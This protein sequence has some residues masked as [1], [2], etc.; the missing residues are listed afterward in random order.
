[1]AVK[2]YSEQALV[3]N[4]RTIVIEFENA[5]LDFQR[6]REL[7]YEYGLE[8]NEITKFTDRSLIRRLAYYV[9][10]SY[11]W[12]GI[13]IEDKENEPLEKWWWHLN[14]IVK[15]E[16]PI[17]LLPDHL[18]DIYVERYLNKKR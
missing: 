11:K 13:K 7:I 1:M 4:Y 12:H 3:K 18:K 16:Y 14:T 6:Q 15:G 10:N 9:K 8:N 17:E 2:R 5:P